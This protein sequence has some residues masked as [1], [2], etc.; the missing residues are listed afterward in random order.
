MAAPGPDS[1]G[2][3]FSSVPPVLRLRCTYFPAVLFAGQ[4]YLSLTF[5]LK[6]RPFGP[7][8]QCGFL[9][10]D[11]VTGIFFHPQ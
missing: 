7:G 9:D 5:T 1:Q 4:V 6:T 10:S 3:I 11:G 8:F 2:R